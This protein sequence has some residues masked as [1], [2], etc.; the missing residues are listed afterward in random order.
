MSQVPYQSRKCRGLTL[1][2]LV[3]LG[4]RLALPSP[5]DVG[6]GLTVADQCENR[7]ARGEMLID[8]SG[9]GPEM[10]EIVERPQSLSIVA[11]DQPRD[12]GVGDESVGPPPAP[13]EKRVEKALQ[14]TAMGHH[15]RPTMGAEP[16]RQSV[17]GRIGP[18]GNIGEALPGE[19]HA[20]V[21]AGDRL[22]E[23]FA[24]V[25]DHLVVGHALPLPEVDLDEVIVD[26]DVR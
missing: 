2:Q 17:D 13:S 4:V 14:D 23:Q 1:T 25:A 16:G 15:R 5:L 6:R 11:P 8:Q 24:V 10:A 19:P 9:A 26:F 20:H 7:A 18:R 3:E 21:S 12:G 22:G